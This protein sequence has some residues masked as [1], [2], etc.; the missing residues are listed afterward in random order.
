MSRKEASVM[1]T[2]KFDGET[3]KGRYRSKYLEGKN[4]YLSQDRRR[5]AM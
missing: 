5:P 4:T 1:T 2:S 3:S